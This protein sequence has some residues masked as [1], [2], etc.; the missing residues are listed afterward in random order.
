VRLAD[1]MPSDDKSVGR[2]GQAEALVLPESLRT[3]QLEPSSPRS[4]V[5]M[6]SGQ[7]EGS[8]A[9]SKALPLRT[10]SARCLCAGRLAEFP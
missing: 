5:R 4:M 1:A 7:A 2:E 8:T 9:E 3:S 10:A 6:L